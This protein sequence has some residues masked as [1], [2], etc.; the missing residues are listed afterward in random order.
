MK[1]IFEL[2]LVLKLSPHCYV[3]NDGFLN[4]NLDAPIAIG[5]QCRA[6]AEVAPSHLL[7]AM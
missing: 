7:G 2:K 1:R 6:K 4:R 5:S 3:S